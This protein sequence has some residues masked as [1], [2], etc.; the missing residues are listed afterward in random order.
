MKRPSL[1]C[2]WSDLWELYFVELIVFKSKRPMPTLDLI[3]SVSSPLH[4]ES[5]SPA[6]SPACT[7]LQLYAPLCPPSCRPWKTNTAA[8]L[9][10][11]IGPPHHHQRALSKLQRRRR[12]PSYRS[13]SLTQSSWWVISTLSSSLP[14]HQPHNL[15]ASLQSHPQPHQA[16]G[17]LCSNK[18]N[19]TSVLWQ[20]LSSQFLMLPLPLATPNLSSK[21]QLNTFFF[22]PRTLLCLKLKQAS[23][24][25]ISSSSWWQGWFWGGCRTLRMWGL[26]WRK[27]VTRTRTS[28]SHPP[29]VLDQLSLHHYSC[30]EKTHHLTLPRWTRIL[31]F[32]CLWWRSVTLCSLAAMYTTPHLSLSCQGIL[33]QRHGRQ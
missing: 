13:Y 19:H 26:S 16:L 6:D 23:V 21:T 32:I 33:S 25:N 22:L 30:E 15:T 29:L 17:I 5:P 20:T 3:P 7:S 9:A 28:K 4:M 18:L 10:L 8:P 14:A 27:W 12:K 24:L 2:V 1:W 31:C 11:S